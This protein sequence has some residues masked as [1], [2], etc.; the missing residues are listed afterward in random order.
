MTP[1]PPRTFGYARF[2]AQR[3]TDFMKKAIPFLGVMSATGRDYVGPLVA[4]AATT[5]NNV[6]NRVAWR[7]AVRTAVVVSK[8]HGS[9]RERRRAHP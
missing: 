5:R 2:A 9:P 8:Q 6:I 1:A 3:P 4:T 7:I